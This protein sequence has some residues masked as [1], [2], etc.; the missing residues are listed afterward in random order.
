MTAAPVKGFVFF[1]SLRARLLF[2][3]LLIEA[4]MLVILVANSV[5]LIQQHMIRQAESRIAAI[6][7]AYKTALAAPLA[8]RDYATLRDILE[9]WLSAKDVLYIAVADRAGKPLVSLGKRGTTASK[10]I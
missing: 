7:L 6:E 2:A 10:A 4:V 3:T 5:R 1:R 8:S 9:G